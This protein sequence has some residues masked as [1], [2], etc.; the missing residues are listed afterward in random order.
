MKH[1]K[2]VGR[3][4][5]THTPDLSCYSTGKRPAHMNPGFQ[6]AGQPAPTASEPLRMHQKLARGRG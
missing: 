2:P 5:I 3:A 1:P 4:R 6:V